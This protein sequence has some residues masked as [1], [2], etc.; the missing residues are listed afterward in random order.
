M[1]NPPASTSAG[2]HPRRLRWFDSR[3]QIAVLV[4]LAAFFL[5]WPLWRLPF[6]MEIAGNEGWNAYFADAVRDGV[7]LYPPTDTLI[8]NNYPPLS[9]YALGL[10]EK[11]FGGDALYIGRV[12]SVL[13]LLACALLIARI[14]RQLGGAKPAAAVAG[15]WFVAIMARSFDR[16]VG[17][18][19]PQLVAHCAMLTSLS[20]FLARERGGKSAVPPIL[21]MVVAGFWKHN[22]V[23][24][25]AATL[26]WLLLQDGRRAISPIVLGAG[27]AALGLALCVAAFGDVFIANLLTPRPYS[28]VRALSWLGRL[29]WVLPALVVWALWA[30]SN[31]RDQAARFSA[32]FIAIALAV[33]VV[34]T[35]SEAVLINAQFDLV[36]ATAIGLGLAYDGAGRT[37]FGR[38]Y[39]ADAARALMVLVLVARLAM[40]LRIESLLILADP[41]YRAEFFANAAIT[42]AEARRV[43]AIPGPVACYYKVVCR[44]AGKP[45]VYDDFRAEMLIATGIAAG[46]TELE[47][48]HEHGLTFAHEDPA[49]GI[50]TLYR[51]LKPWP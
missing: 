32:L 15:V 39:G 46:K 12:L 42:R 50:G 37:A 25:P 41:S 31:R 3:A 35:S 19:D 11:L 38:D 26:A 9:F 18:N 24:V 22:V 30:W 7:P 6:P 27:A 40:T 44:L 20:W 47:L 5:V 48:M 17:M 13:A 34:Q 10:A 49:V 33:Y 4:L 45:Y 51:E 21:L 1:N 29:Q 36:I 16:F 23:A 43:A 2:T 28:V 14:V 8:V